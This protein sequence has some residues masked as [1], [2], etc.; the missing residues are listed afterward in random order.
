MTMTFTLLNYHI[1]LLH[2][3]YALT[4]NG[5]NAL[6]HCVPNSMAAVLVSC[7]LLIVT[8][9]DLVNL[10]KLILPQGFFIK[11]FKVLS[12][13]ILLIVTKMRGCFCLMI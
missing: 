3:I 10:L 9:V 12:S 5:G 1:Q 8:V 11:I 4:H 2:V 13:C 7:I 6:S